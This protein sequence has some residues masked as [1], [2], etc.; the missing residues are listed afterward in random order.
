M[1]LEQLLLNKLAEEAAELSQIASKGAIFGINTYSPCYENDT[2]SIIIKETNDVLGILRMLRHM[3]DIRG[4]TNSGKFDD[5]NKTTPLIVKEVKTF[6]YLQ[7]LITSDELVLTDNERE[8]LVS[9]VRD[10]QCFLDDKTKEEIASHF[11]E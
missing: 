5:I 7:R 8:W 11:K 10:N 2:L 4:D 3:L 6:S 9:V 1:N